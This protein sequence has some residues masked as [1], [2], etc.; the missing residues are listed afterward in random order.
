ME[1]NYKKGNMETWN[2]VA[3]RYHKR[4]AEQMCGPMQSTEKLISDLGVRQGDHVLDVACG[5][6]MVTKML[7]R[8]V[9]RTG[10]VVGADTSISAIQIAKEWSQGEISNTDFVNADAENFA[11]VNEFDVVTCQYGLFFFPDAPK[12]LANM[13]RSLK[14]YTGRMGIVVHGSNTPF[15]TAILRAAEEYIP[16]YHP[17][18]APRF[19]RYATKDGLQRE[20]QGAGFTNITVKDYVF[21]YSPGTFEEYWKE[22]QRYVPAQVR[23]KIDALGTDKTRRFKDEILRN[24]AP[25]TEDDTGIITFPWQVLVLT[26]MR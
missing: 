5:T 19:D 7:S 3:P 23:A 22:Y 14:E 2:E 1:S 6:G 18:G 25:Y 15:F 12:A 10:R 13:R 26:A 8:A 21:V 4:W 20:V 24:T 11:F 17:A 16:D 9:G